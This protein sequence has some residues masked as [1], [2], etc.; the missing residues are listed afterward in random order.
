MEQK[1][2]NSKSSLL[3]KK[4]KKSKNHLEKKLIKY[5]QIYKTLIYVQIALVIL[6]LIALNIYFK[7]LYKKVYFVTRDIINQNSYHKYILTFLLNSIFQMFFIPGISFYIIF[8][9]FITKNYLETMLL[10]YPSTLIIVFI[11]YYITKFTIKKCLFQFLKDK[12]FFRCYYEES[13]KCPM[14]TSIMLRILLIPATYKNYIISLMKI[15]FCCYFIPAVFHYWPYYSI[16]ALLGVFLR[17]IGEVLNGNIPNHNQKVYFVFLGF[18]GLLVLL[19]IL[20]IIYFSVL[21]CRVFREFKK[22]DEAKK[23]EEKQENLLDENI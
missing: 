20:I 8:I 10:I 19:S 16:Y 9:G 23:K 5:N 11:T 12:W 13:E 18:M 17:D 14:K 2:E 21:T 3:E 4:T 7:D 22:K 15:N 1:I 6:L